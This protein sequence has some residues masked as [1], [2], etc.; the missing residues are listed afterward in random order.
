MG[1]GYA[2][3]ICGGV[4]QLPGGSWVTRVFGV[5]GVRAIVF[6][7]SGGKLGR[8]FFRGSSSWFRFIMNRRGED[9]V[10]VLGGSRRGSGVTPEIVVMV[11]GFCFG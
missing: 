8:G 9:R 7:D 5:R 6:D 11:I 3:A 4:V 2:V 10:R 1:D